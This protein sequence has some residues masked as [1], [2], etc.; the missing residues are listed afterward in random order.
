MI[1]EGQTT[2]G[3]KR[4]SQL[5]SKV[6]FL[7]YSEIRLCALFSCPSVAS[8]DKQPVLDQLFSAN[9]KPVVLP[10]TASEFSNGIRNRNCLKYA[11]AREDRSQCPLT[12]VSSRRSRTTC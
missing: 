7:D 6:F 3:R 9:L 2:N 5:E 1:R 11:I 8:S 4:K 12:R 10:V